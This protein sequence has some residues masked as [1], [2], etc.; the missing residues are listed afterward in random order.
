M[1]IFFFFFYIM[2]M[3]LVLLPMIYQFKTLVVPILFKQ[4]LYEVS[5]ACL[6]ALNLLHIHS[7]TLRLMWTL[8]LIMSV[9]NLVCQPSKICSTAVLIIRIIIRIVS[10]FFFFFFYYN[11]S[12]YIIFLIFFTKKVEKRPTEK[13]VSVICN[14]S[15]RLEYCMSAVA[16]W[17]RS[18]RVQ[19][20]L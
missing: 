12:Q 16:A 9:K 2:N 3:L 13:P 18:T 4:G 6:P 14:K 17:E 5:P 10:T 19:K 11:N 20:R 1:H 7:C 8:E 15:Q